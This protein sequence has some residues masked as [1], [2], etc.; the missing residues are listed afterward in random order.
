MQA[1][2]VEN[3]E[4]SKN[5]SGDMEMK[6]TAENNTNKK[7]LTYFELRKK[8]RKLLLEIINEN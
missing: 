6:K 4:N 3:D 8:L 2:T 7:N 1:L 5:I